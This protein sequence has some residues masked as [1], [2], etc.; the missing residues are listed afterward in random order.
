MTDMPPVRPQPSTTAQLEA[1]ILRASW[2]RC[3]NEYGLR[4]NLRQP[5]IY[6]PHE[7]VQDAYKSM[8]ELIASS[9]PIIDRVRETARNSD[10]CVLLCNTDGTVVEGYADSSAANELADVGLRQG[11][12]WSEENVGTNG[13]GTCLVARSPITIRGGNHYN[14]ALRGFNCC[15][16]PFYAPDGSVLGALDLSGRSATDFSE[17]FFVEYFVRE[18]A[19]NISRQLFRKWHH[20]DRIV[21]LAID[22]TGL[23]I[24]P[25]AMIAANDSGQII[26]A[27]REALTMLGVTEVSALEHKTVDALWN[28]SIDDLRPMTTN[29][30]R[31]STA[32]G[33]DAYALTYQPQP[34]HGGHNSH[35]G[36]PRQRFKT[37][38]AI[39]LDGH[40]LAEPSKPTPLDDIAGNDPQME[41]CV[42]L[43][44]KLLDS[45]LPILLLGETGVGKD[46]FARAFHDE[47]D[48]CDKP[49][50]AVNCA[51]IPD[52]LLA[53][54]LF[55]YAP[56]AF[57][58]GLE[59]GNDG[60]FVACNGGTMFL[61]EIG[62]MPIEQ[63]AHLLRILEEQEIT[64]LGGVDSISI[65]VRII[66]GTDQKLNDKVVKG[67]FRRDL[68]YRIKGAELV[69]SPLRQRCDIRK[70]VST[71]IAEECGNGAV[72][73]VPESV[74]DVFENYAWPGNIRELKGILHLILSTNDSDNITI[75]MLPE[76]LL[77]NSGS[78]SYGRENIATSLRPSISMTP[79]TTLEDT[80]EQAERYRIVQAL[81]VNKWCVTRAAKELAISR[82]TL[83]RKIR[84]YEITSPNEQQ[85]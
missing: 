2:D 71:I 34:R 62:D 75:E 60:K 27:T 48:R 29:H 76:D 26:G 21:A 51:A 84:K 63:Q 69:L 25:T 5:I 38:Q 80:Q 9:T 67:L 43:S 42:R 85:G 15:A 14:K 19:A 20:A 55:G 50:I 32:D 45:H 11:T 24:S 6:V 1:N 23:E 3:S 28:V 35:A 41:K 64:P 52:P 59:S 10:Y 74:F 22:P 66:C 47:S 16:A 65:D 57:A 70:I 18:A 30:V 40:D 33:T 46:R 72:V 12:H 73:D 37:S 53:S 58:N 31:L 13:I 61:D 8:E 81:S 17:L 82:A 7:Q 44:R 49:F 77:Q 54:E 39:T 78:T 56:G 83:H 79:A 36:P 68:Y 4:K